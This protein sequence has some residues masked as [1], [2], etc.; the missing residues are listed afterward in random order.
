MEDIKWLLKKWGFLILML[1]I[2]VITGVICW[3]KL[4]T[5]ERKVAEEVWEPP[6]EIG[7][8]EMIRNACQTFRLALRIFLHATA[9][10]PPSQHDNYLK[11]MNLTEIWKIGKLHLYRF[12]LFTKAP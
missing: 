11:K 3:G 10:V 8:S 1:L 2:V 7:D 9:A 6:A 4:H 5:E 12:L